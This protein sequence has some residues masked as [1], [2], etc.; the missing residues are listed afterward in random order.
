MQETAAQTKQTNKF[1]CASRISIARHDKYNKLQEQTILN[2][3]YITTSIHRIK[4]VIELGTKQKLTIP[5][6]PWPWQ[7]SLATIRIECLARHHLGR[8]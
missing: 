5:E 7:T 8:W 6:K 2:I 4:T 1:M 3:I